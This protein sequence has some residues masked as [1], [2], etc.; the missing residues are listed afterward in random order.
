[1]YHLKMME[2]FMLMVYLK[3]NPSLLKKSNGWNPKYFGGL[4]DPDKYN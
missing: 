4:N 2:N 1:M 3:C